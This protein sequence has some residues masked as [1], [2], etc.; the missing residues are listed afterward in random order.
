MSKKGDEFFLHIR[1]ANARLTLVN[2]K[3]SGGSA[4]YS[5]LKN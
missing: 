2:R 3:S 5:M 1:I 4:T